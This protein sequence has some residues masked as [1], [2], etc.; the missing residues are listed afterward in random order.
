MSH[1]LSEEDQD[2]LNAV[3]RYEKYPS[4]QEWIADYIRMRLGHYRRDLRFLR[5]LEKQ[6]KVVE[7]K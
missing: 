3:Y 7:V 1:L 6:V 4:E 2:L 5:W